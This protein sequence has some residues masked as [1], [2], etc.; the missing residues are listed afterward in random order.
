MLF[1]E[2]EKADPALFDLL[3]G[4]M[5]KSTLALGDNTTVDFSNSI[6]FLTSNLGSR[7]M[8]NLIDGGLGF[9]A[10]PI[11]TGDELEG[12][13]IEQQRLRQRKIFLQ[14]L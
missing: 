4:I 5:D 14:S 3:L 13:F 11:E 10:G 9:G 1:D 7:E 8:E 2:I 6:I 12:K